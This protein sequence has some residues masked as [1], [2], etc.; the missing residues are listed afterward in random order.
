[1][2][3][4]IIWA[5]PPAITR[6][7]GPSKWDRILEQ[8]QAKPG[9]WAMFPWSSKNSATS[10]ARYLKNKFPELDV[11]VRGS[12]LYVRWTSKES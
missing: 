12:D 6:N 11:T 2:M 9:Q 7:R 5:D 8:L 3:E 1:M 4:K 10:T